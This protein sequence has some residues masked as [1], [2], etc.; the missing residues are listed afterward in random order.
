MIVA[1]CVAVLVTVAV[2]PV[3]SMIAVIIAIVA[4]VFV[5]TASLV[6]GERDGCAER[7]RQSGSGSD[8]KPKLRRHR[9]PQFIGNQEEL[10]E[11][12][13]RLTGY[14]RSRPTKRLHC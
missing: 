3:V 12:G 10:T 8:S 6:L 11:T 9:T 1:T 2:L 5:V 7:Q 4:I 14:G 13:P